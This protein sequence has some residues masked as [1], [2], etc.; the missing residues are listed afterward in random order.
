[1]TRLPAPLSDATRCATGLLDLALDRSVVLG[2]TSLGP[3]VRSLWWPDDRGFAGLAGR[4]V[5]V[6]GA[7][8]GLGEAIAAG[9]ADA[10]AVV[11]LLGRDPGRVEAAVARVRSSAQHAEVTGELC[12]LG[13]LDAVRDFADDLA[14]RC[15][16]L[17]GLVHNAG[18][19]P[20]ERETSPQGH[21]LTLAVHV[22]G[23]HLLTERLLAPLTAA[24]R[25]VVVWMAS[26]G[27]YGAR[28]HDEDLQYERGRYDGVQAYART[29]RM[30][31]VV[32]DAWAGRA[33]ETGVQSHSMHPGWAATPGI[34]ASLPRFARLTAPLLR[35]P[36]E[37]ADTAL[38]LLAESPDS[39]PTGHNF[40][41]DRARRPTTFGWQRPHDREAVGRLL[42]Q[43]TRLTGTRAFGG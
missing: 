20:P 11:H 39:E 31:V 36:A 7:T 1:M 17:D 26:G 33:V 3:R 43:V 37:G 24:D 42:D 21:E 22:L 6:T 29:K 41:H 4:R 28:L 8:S 38:W 15:P 5:L 13:D 30:Q 23:P 32:A 18:V 9:L 2:Y 35:T 25:A 19:L 12:D 27:M 10:G 14:E 34:T 16:T 40:W